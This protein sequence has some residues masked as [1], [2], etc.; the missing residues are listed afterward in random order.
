MAGLSALAL[1][2]AVV[3]VSAC[4]STRGGIQTPAERVRIPTAP[5]SN[6]RRFAYDGLN[7]YYVIGNALTPGH[8]T[9]TL[10]VAPLGDEPRPTAMHAWIDR[11]IG[12]RL[13]TGTDGAFALTADV[14]NLDSGEHEVLLAADGEDA[15]FARLTFYR[16]HPLY[17]V[18]SSDWDDAD[19]PDV[20]LELQEGLRRKHPDLVITHFVGPY[21]FTDPLLTEERRALLARWA[22]GMRDT[23]GDEIGMHLHPWCHFIEMTGVPCRITPST[24]E[25]TGDRTGY[26]V[27]VASYSEQESIAI[28]D[29]AKTIFSTRGLGTPTSFRAGGWTAGANTMRALA[30]TGF[31]VDSSAISWARLAAE[32]EGYDL[33]AWNKTQWAPIGDTS[34]PWYPSIANLLGDAAPHVPVLE[35]PD[36]GNLVDYI[37]AGE[38]IDVFTKNWTG[39]PGALTEPRQLSIGYHPTTLFQSDLEARLDSALRHIDRYQAKNGAGPVVYTRLSDL[40]KVWHRGGPAPQ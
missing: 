31:T 21:T 6:D 9:L 12:V 19:S 39:R 5:A 7:G 17:V 11:G 2:M 28:L 35:V 29:A 3:F 4:G 16:T 34:Q 24:V 25:P 36:N 10:T 18:V 14:S 1:V 33:Y 8:D 13:T 15:A 27:I 26:S 38:M 23:F 22:A 32:W 30:A 20:S 40:T 37:T